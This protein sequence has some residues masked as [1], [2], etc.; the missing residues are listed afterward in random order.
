MDLGLS[1]KRALVLGASRGL[2]AAIA[3][4]LAA[5][6]AAVIA[7]ARSTDV[8]DGWIAALPADQRSR[9]VAAKLDL[10]DLGSVDALADR[11]V[12]EGGVDILIGNSGGP[13]P[14]RRAMPSA[15]TG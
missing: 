13:P 5:E 6:G 3:R 1:G 10:A 4:T 11:L 8:T 9:V 7:A 2:G 15:T 14:A 12:A